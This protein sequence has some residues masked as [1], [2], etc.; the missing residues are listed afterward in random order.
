MVSAAT[1]GSAASTQL[2]SSPEHHEPVVSTPEMVDQQD[3]VEADVR[4]VLARP[5]KFQ[6]QLVRFHGT[7]E[8]MRV[9]PPREGYR[10]GSDKV[11]FT[12]FRTQMLIEAEFNDGNSEDVLVVI[13]VDPEKIH[14]DRYVEVVATHAGE[15]IEEARGGG[16]W[17]WPYFVAISVD[18][19]TRP[20]N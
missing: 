1:S 10:T 12:F 9:A 11:G 7:V 20:E 5:W 16:Y 3:I 17:Q 13:N 4:D 19:E 15:H 6:D 2:R 18:P 14:K 8:E